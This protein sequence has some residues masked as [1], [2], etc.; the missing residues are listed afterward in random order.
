MNRR[1]FLKKAF[2]MGV[3]A[4]AAV[5]FGKKTPTVFAEEKASRAPGSP[6]LVAVRGGEPDAMFDAGIKEFGGMSRFVHNGQTVLVKPN[7]GWNREPAFAA[8]TNPKLVSQIV[9]HCMQAGAAKVIV[10]DHTCDNGPRCY[11]TSGIA[12]AARD[13][14]ATVVPGDDKKYYREVAIP[15]AKV[16]KKALVHEALLDCDVFINVPVLK[17]HSSTRL[18]ISMKNLMG[19][20]WDRGFWHA[21]DLDQCIAD[22]AKFRKPDLTVVDAYAIMTDHGPRGISRDDIVVKKNL[23]LSPDPVL[24]DAAA[25][26]IFG[27]DPSTIRHITVAHEQHVGRMNTEGR[28]IRRI[29]L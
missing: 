17:S 7:I 27:I 21:N 24:A 28:I 16:L 4:G 20:V 5:I 2:Q 11:E 26:K 29:A 25:A 1:E 13:A 15:G 22:F 19:T 12:K 8:N 18:T 10:F 9:R 3:F 6:E 23:L 14:G